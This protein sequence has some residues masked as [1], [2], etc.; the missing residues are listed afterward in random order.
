[1]SNILISYFTWS[2]NLRKIA[3][4]I[5]SYTEGD[6]FEITPQNPYPTD[7]FQAIYMVQKENEEDIYPKL[8]SEINTDNYDLILLGSPV[9]RYTVAP[10]VKT[11]LKTN[12]F[13]GKKIAPFVSYGDN[14]VG[15]IEADILQ[16]AKGAKLLEPLKIYG[17]GESETKDEISSWLEFLNII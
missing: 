15:T 14:G 17:T 11:F 3:K 4:E 5:Q 6:L 10:P 13:S 2:G 16:Y 8:K 12:N 9:W 7:Y 1:M